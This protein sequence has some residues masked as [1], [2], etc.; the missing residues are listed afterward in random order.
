VD[1]SEIGHAIAA[2]GGGRIRIEDTIDPT[3]GFTAQLKI[4]DRVEVGESLGLV[5]CDDEDKGREAVNRIQAAYTVD[6]MNT[7]PLPLIKEVINE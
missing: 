1:T 5:F 7:A 6:H 3:V 4:G 2:I